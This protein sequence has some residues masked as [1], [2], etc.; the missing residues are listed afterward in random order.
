[1]KKRSSIFFILLLFCT[2]FLSFSQDDDGMTLLKND[3]SNL[4]KFENH[5]FEAL[6]YK[7]IGNY[8]RAITELE[9][10]QQLFSDDISVVFELSKNYFL[11]NKFVE[12]ESYIENVLERDSDNYWFIEQAKKVSLKQYK[13]EIAIEFQKKLVSKKPEKAEDLVLIY[14]QARK[15]KE[16]QRVI[17]E[18]TSNKI[19]SSKLDHYQKIILKR[20]GKKAIK[21]KINNTTDLSLEALKKSFKDNQ[22]YTILKEILTQEITN[23]NFDI[24]SIY[25]NKGLELFPAQPLVYLMNAKGL[26]HSKKYNEAIDVL[27]NG[28]DFVVDDINLEI[29]FYKQQIICFEALN[30]GEKAKKY[31]EKVNRLKTSMNK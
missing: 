6:K 17:N 3:E 13:Y 28:I 5:Y 2:S 24:L 31:L 4:I 14:I 16:A 30:Q 7:A 18:L 9:K 15:Y 29:D 21:E 8:T 19:T 10:C 25:S 11:L 22:Q 27:N 26:I 20:I 23:K 1:M 12:A